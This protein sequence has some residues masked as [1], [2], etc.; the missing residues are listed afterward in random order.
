MAWLEGQG[1][2]NR[3][4]GLFW[5]ACTALEAGDED[6]IGDLAAAALSAGPDEDEVRRTIGSAYKKVTDDGR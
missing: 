3:N 5:A 2:G 4:S 1:Q 6:V